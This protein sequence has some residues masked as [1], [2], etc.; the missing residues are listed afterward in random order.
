MKT[1]HD[2]LTAGSVGLVFGMQHA[3]EKM[4]LGRMRIF[5]QHGLR[6]MS[7]A[8]DGR[9]EYGTGFKGTDALTEKGNCSESFI[10]K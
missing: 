10:R 4:T 2:L 9:N 5:Q 6:I 1:K 3:P 7:L 8:Y